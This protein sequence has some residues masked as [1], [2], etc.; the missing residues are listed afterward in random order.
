MGRRNKTH[1]YEEPEEEVFCKY[2]KGSDGKCKKTYRSR[3]EANA[4]VAHK[5]KTEGIRLEVY[6]CDTGKGFHLTKSK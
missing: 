1:Y 6:D 2:C 3:A 5:R 4:V